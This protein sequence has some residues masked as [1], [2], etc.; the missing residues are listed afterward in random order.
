MGIMF[1]AF[2]I[3]KTPGKE[4]RSNGIEKKVN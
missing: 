2:F 1:R 3:I 4:E